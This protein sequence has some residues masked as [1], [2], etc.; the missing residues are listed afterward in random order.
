MTKEEEDLLRMLHETHF[1]GAFAI[2]CDGKLRASAHRLEEL[3]FAEWKGTNWGSSFYAITDAG[4]R[5]AS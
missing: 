2:A 4:L 5:H 3:G 1:S